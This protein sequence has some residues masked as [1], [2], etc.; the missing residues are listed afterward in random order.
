V[1]RQPAVL[2]DR[3]VSEKAEVNQKKADTGAPVSDAGG[4]AEV[5][6]DRRDSR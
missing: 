3:P 1:D 2:V 5:D 4:T 6:L